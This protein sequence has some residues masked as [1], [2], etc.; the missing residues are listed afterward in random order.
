MSFCFLGK[1]KK[2]ITNLSCAELAPSVEKVNNRNYQAYIY[3]KKKKK[4]KK[5]K[6][7]N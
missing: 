4:T 7:K 6:K 5:K 1:N 3:K 2:N